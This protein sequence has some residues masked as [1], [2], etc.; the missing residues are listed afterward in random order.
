M[1][2]TASGKEVVKIL[3]KEFGF[4][5]VSQKGSHVKLSKQTSTGHVSTVVPMHHELAH[6]TLRGAL[7]LARVDFKEFERFL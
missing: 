7:D 3:M 5:F 1:P 6:G 2:K 4:L